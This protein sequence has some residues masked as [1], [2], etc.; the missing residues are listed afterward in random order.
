MYQQRIILCYTTF[1]AVSFKLG[2]AISASSTLTPNDVEKLESAIDSL[3][4]KCRP[5][6]HLFCQAEAKA[7]HRLTF[8]VR[9]VV[10][11]SV[12]SLAFQNTTMY[13]KWFTPT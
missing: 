8:V 7:Q 2:F 6:R 1:S 9:S 13:R 10:A 12:R 11:P 3:P 4:A 5:I